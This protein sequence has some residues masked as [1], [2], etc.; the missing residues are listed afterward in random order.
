MSGTFSLK[1]IR[2]AITLGA[3]T[4]SGGGST[5]IIEGL[6]CEATIL[7]PGLP[8][9]NSAN[10][11]VWGLPYADMAQLTML[12]FKPLESEHNLIEIRAGEAGSALP[13]IFQGE[14]TGA[15]ADFNNSPDPCMRFEADSGSYPQQMATPV[16]TVK[17][18]VQADKLFARFA[19]EA[20]YGYDNEGVSSSVRDAWFP[21][22]PVDKMVK[23]ARDVGCELLIDDGRVIVLPAGAA[24]NGSP[25][26]LSKHTGMIGYP[27]FTQNGIACRCLFNPDLAYA[28]LIKINSLVPRANGEWR[29]TKLSH[30]LSAH[31][32]GGGSWESRIEAAFTE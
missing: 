5:K 12:A 26:S 8:E 28:G 7:K 30:N 3:G 22:S 9:K 19:T 27:T 1:T 29:I 18:E 25:V 31:T 20:G 11:T 6:A 2:I 32:P 17:G 21:G 24:R 13:L 10:V 14:I 4:F 23:L 15:S 16:V